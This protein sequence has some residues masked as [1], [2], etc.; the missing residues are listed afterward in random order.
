MEEDGWILVDYKTDRASREELLA[1]YELQ[2]QWYARALAQITR[3]PV[4]EAL[5]FGLREKE[6]IPVQ[7]E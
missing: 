4:K 6:A 1:R 3:R 2:I 5:I 7:L